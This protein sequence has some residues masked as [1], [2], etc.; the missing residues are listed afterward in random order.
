MVVTP[1][2]AGASPLPFWPLTRRVVQPSLSSSCIS[3]H[4]TKLCYQEQPAACLGPG[5]AASQRS[6]PKH[7][8]A[9]FR[10]ASL[11]SGH[12]AERANKNKMLLPFLLAADFGASERALTEL[13]EQLAALNATTNQLKYIR[14]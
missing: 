2:A 6:L 4:P 7:H 14:R 8:T 12:C 13:N 1:A 11:P 3:T 10:S 5:Q 9:C